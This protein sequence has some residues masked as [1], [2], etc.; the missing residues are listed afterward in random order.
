MGYQYVYVKSKELHLTVV[1]D[2]LAPPVPAA[3]FL[4]ESHELDPR[5]V[6][7]LKDMFEAEE[8][9]R[10]AEAAALANQP[11]APTP[12]PPRHPDVRKLL[13]ETTDDL[14]GDLDDQIAKRDQALFP[15]PP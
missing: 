12:P 6:P 14:L 5:E 13:N 7:E 11:K 9:A 2:D 1:T 8:A 3:V 10:L 15:P 4:H